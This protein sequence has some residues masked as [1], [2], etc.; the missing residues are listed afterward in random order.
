MLFLGQML[1]SVSVKRDVERNNTVHLD[2]ENH[3][4]P[5]TESSIAKHIQALGCPGFV[6]VWQR[7]GDKLR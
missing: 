2:S 3:E 5:R 7:S 6:L 1:V 4:P